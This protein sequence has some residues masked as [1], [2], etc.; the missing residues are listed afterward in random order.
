MRSAVSSAD[1][2]WR[3]WGVDGEGVE[4]EEEDERG[5]VRHRGFLVYIVRFPW[6]SPTRDDITVGSCGSG[7]GS[8]R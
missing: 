1:V 6:N 7:R 2:D 8:L 5:S 3:D 4:E